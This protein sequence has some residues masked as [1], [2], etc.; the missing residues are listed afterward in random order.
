METDKKIQR[1]FAIHIETLDKQ[2]HSI[3]TDDKDD[4]EEW[5]KKKKKQ[6]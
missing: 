2:H 4:F 1:E 6:T 5:V 3:A